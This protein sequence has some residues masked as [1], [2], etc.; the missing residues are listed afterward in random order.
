MFPRGLWTKRNQWNKY[1]PTVISIALHFLRHR[2]L[3]EFIVLAGL[4][5]VK[6][7][8]ELNTVVL[9]C[10]NIIIIRLCK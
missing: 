8:G 10:A 7:H 3:N 1:V 9:F 5:V 4:Q 2:Y 6:L